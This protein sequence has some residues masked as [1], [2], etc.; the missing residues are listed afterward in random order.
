MGTNAEARGYHREQHLLSSD[1]NLRLQVHHLTH[2]I[3]RDVRVCPIN[4]RDLQKM[5]CKSEGVGGK[6]YKKF[7]TF[8]SKLT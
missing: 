5:T 6:L 8:N 1:A 2:S 7:V 3:M 4:I